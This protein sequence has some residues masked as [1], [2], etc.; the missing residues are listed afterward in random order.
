MPSGNCSTMT[1]IIYYNFKPVEK[2]RQ[3]IQISGNVTYLKTVVIKVRTHMASCNIDTV[4]LKV[5]RC[6][7]RLY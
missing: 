3:S 7:Q 5:N 4:P 6:A 2:A 1:T